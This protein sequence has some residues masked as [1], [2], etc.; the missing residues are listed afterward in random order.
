MFTVDSLTA[1]LNRL[2]TLTASVKTVVGNQ[3]ATSNSVNTQAEAVTKA[4]QVKLT[5]LET[6][7]K[8]YVPAA[9]TA[10]SLASRIETDVMGFVHGVENV[11]HATAV[12]PVHGVEALAGDVEVVAKDVEAEIAKIVKRQVPPA[13]MPAPI[14]AVVVVP[15]VSD[16]SG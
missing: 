8:D 9:N 5:E 15:V 11:G 7:L 13:A 12:A 1:E 10:P 4:I 6:F 14:P 2:N 16:I 3:V